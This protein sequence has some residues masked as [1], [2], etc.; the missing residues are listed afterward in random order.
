VSLAGHFRDR[1]ATHVHDPLQVRCLVLDDSTTQLVLVMV[2]SCMVP[3]DLFDAAKKV[4][5]HT[6]GIPLSNMLMAATHT[7]TAPSSVS[8]F[9]S[10]PVPGY[11]EL[12]KA[13][14][15]EGVCEAYKCRVPAQIAWGSGV[16]SDEVFNRRWFMKPGTLPADPF[17]KTTDRVRMNPPRASEDLIESAGSIDPEIPFIAVRHKN[18]KP[19]AILANYALHY[20]G[21]T[22][23]GAMSADY[24]GCFAASLTQLLRAAP[25]ETPF[26]AML[27]NGASANINNIDF[28][29]PGSAA[30]PYEQ[31]NAVAD[32]AAQ[33]VYRVYQTLTFSDWLPLAAATRDLMLGTRRPQKTELL[34]AQSIVDAASS[35]IMKSTEEVFARET[36]LLKH[37]PEQVSVPLQVLRIG[38]I[39]IAAIPCEIFVETGLYLKKESPFP[40]AFPIALANGYNGYLPTA[41]QHALGGYETWRARS[42]Y[43]EIHA[44]KKIQDNIID[45]L[46]VL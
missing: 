18:G 19:L 20:V 8:I 43:L 31:M 41:E 26:L 46:Q 37:Y 22:D 12:V 24:F 4:I 36:L 5:H 38:D 7:H 30:D 33:E 28:S 29:K 32:K 45:M 6:L 25:D 34:R 1:Q 9:Q 35:E 16:V 10:D 42:S 39:A 2:D 11:A 17:G 13:A 23:A 27:S 21:G 15:V 44:A 40:H 3:R 14:L